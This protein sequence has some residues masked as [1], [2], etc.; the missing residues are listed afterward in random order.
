MRQEHVDM[1]DRREVPLT[2]PLRAT[3]AAAS[4]YAPQIL[5]PTNTDR[6]ETGQASRAF[7]VSVPFL[8]LALR[9]VLDHT[10]RTLRVHCA[11]AYAARSRAE[12]ATHNLF[13]YSGL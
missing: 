7:S 9:F 10:A 11:L 13:L 5:V 2:L 3:R 8:V 1:G 4:L 6:T 12:P